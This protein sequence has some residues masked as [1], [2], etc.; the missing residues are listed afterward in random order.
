VPEGLAVLLEAAGIVLALGASLVVAGYGLTRTLIP[1]ALAPFTILLVPAVGAAALIVGSYFLNIVLNMTVTTAV[2]LAATAVFDVWT[3][4]G[5][6][7][8]LP[9]PT[10]SQVV[11]LAAAL[12]LLMVAFLPHLQARSLALL[13]LNIDEDLYVPLAELLRADTVS[14]ENAG[15]GPFRDEFQGARNHSRGWGFPYLL[16]IASVVANTP[17]FHAYVPTLYLLL[18][19]SVPAVFVFGAAGLGLS[20]R[21]A[22][23]GA[24]IYAL[25]G[26]PLWFAGMGFGPHVLSFLLFPTAIASGVVAIRTGGSRAL[27]FAAL[28]SSAL[29][30]SYF[31]AIS[32]V[33]AVVA[34]LLAVVIVMQ[35]PGRY[36]RLRR[37]ILLMFGIAAGAAPGLYWLIRWA[38]PL[39]TDIA[40]DLRGE[41]GNA[42]GD[43]I[44][45]RVELA[46]GMAPYRLVGEVGPLDSETVNTIQTLKD[47]IFWPVLGLAVIGL[48]TL[49][50]NRPVAWAMAAAYAGFMAWVAVG[51]EYEYGHLKNLSYVAYF[52][53]ML[54]ASGIGNVFHGEFALWDSDA[55]ARFKSWLHPLR[56]GLVAVSI[57]G[58]A[59]VTMALAHN[60]VQS[61]WWYWPGIGWQIDRHVAHDARALASLLPGGSRVFFAH[62][63]RIP[64][65]GDRITL[66]D[67][68]LGFHFPQHQRDSLANRTRSIWAAAL[69]GQNVYGFVPTLA[70]AS[71][72]FRLAEDYAFIVLNAD[73]DARTYGLVPEDAVYSTSYWTVFGVPNNDR[74][75][76]AQIATQ[77]PSRL[78]IPSD[79]WLRLGVSE[80]SLAIGSHVSLPPAS[81]LIGLLTPNPGAVNVQISEREHL[82]QID[83]GLTWLTIGGAV[84]APIDLQV[85]TSQDGIQLVAARILP[86]TV[87]ADVS[88]VHV[89]RLAMSVDVFQTDGV[90]H[91]SILGVNPTKLGGDV[92]ITFQETGT[93]GFWRTEVL[94]NTLA[95]EIGFVYHPI[96]RALEQRV[97]GSAP[98]VREARAADTGQRRLFRL[99][100]ERGFVDI[101]TVPILRY[102]VGR[103]GFQH[104]ATLPQVHV[105]DVIRPD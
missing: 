92:G 51:A 44:Q 21:T 85:G 75:T 97:D 73:A 33:Y 29:L 4:R 39:L 86:R 76:T 46:F 18:A 23:L 61:V 28:V 32:V 100:F 98:I 105:F 58:T 37:T 65:T 10:R 12:V 22:A 38:A 6:G 48:I 19:L 93:R 83:P 104:V 71:A 96:S 24:L 59:V 74:L 90:F 11:V 55:S 13:G 89:H 30:I 72:D 43:T 47:G 66:S 57:T 9:R 25:H 17:A 82:V 79:G 53:A 52:V 64:I 50:G 95:N 77:G 16:T 3:I 34:G 70:F 49:R 26:L 68:E 99:E 62:D 20:E 35:G 40:T 7:W 63:L 84:D 8:R 67:H 94:A 69:S 91:G 31:W 101:Y 36:L 5:E 41:F 87:V 80:G 60:T 54:I 103:Q 2:L 15:V 78:G 56:P 27:A 102:A 88:S 42:W 81:I 1:A 45:S 14:L